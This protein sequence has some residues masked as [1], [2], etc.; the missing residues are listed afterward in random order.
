MS[1]VSK[2]QGRTLVTY[3]ETRTTEAK[4]PAFGGLRWPDTAY[5][6]QLR[7]QQPKEWWINMEETWIPD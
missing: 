7:K 6:V 1:P 5:S 4:A 3:G 2:E